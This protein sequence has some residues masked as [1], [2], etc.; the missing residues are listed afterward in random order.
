MI[1]DKGFSNLII[2]VPASILSIEPSL[3]LKTL[4][5]GL[6][7]RAAAIFR[8]DRI[9]IYPGETL[10]WR[11]LG[12]FQL[13]L[14]YMVTAPYLRR[15]LFGID[16]RLRY[17]GILPPLQIPTH[18]VGGPRKGEIRQALVIDKKNKTVIVDAGLR[19]AIQV[20]F[21]EYN[22]SIRKGDLIHIEIVELDPPRAR[23]APN[24]PLYTGYVVETSESLLQ[25]IRKW[26]RCLKIATSRK[27]L[28]IND[29]A[30]DL[31]S[32]LRNSD[33]VLVLFGSHSKGLYE[34][35][36]QEGF[37]L[38]KFVDIVINTVPGQG[39]LTIRTEEAVY[40][41]LALINMLSGQR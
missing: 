13:L 2:G 23:L 6:I 28:P 37:N 31:K 1:A 41:S 20:E 7:G 21:Q 17:A 8:V 19:Q 15:K 32:M 35:A 24:P 27:G 26:S 34:L 25:V 22:M 40:A 39:T 12:L 16:H 29:V 18:G 14:K 9:A 36:E 3:E 38:E 33:C 10:D 30:N 4:K 5:A 11:D